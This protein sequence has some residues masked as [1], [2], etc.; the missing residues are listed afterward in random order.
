[1]TSQAELRSIFN[2]F[3]KT[4]IKK[5]DDGYYLYGNNV[6]VQ[7]IGDIWDVY[8]CNMKEYAQD[9]R[10]ANLGTGKLNNIYAT[11]PE[12]IKVRKLDGEGY[13]QTS[14]LTWLKGWLEGNRQALGIKKRKS[15]PPVHFGVRMDVYRDA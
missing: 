4:A 10:T 5:N 6:N 8:L 7:A 1:M 9:N 11:L 12:N 13:F 2:K 3:A 14:D 15:P